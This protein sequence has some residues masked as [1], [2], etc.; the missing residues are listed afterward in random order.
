MFFAL[1]CVVASPGLAPKLEHRI[2]EQAGTQIRMQHDQPL[3]TGKGWILVHY[4][5]FMADILE[6]AAVTGQQ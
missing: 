3:R 1:R 4:Y 5:L 2:L 6:N